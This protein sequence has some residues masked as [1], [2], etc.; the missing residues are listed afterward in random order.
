M[1]KKILALFMPVALAAFSAQDVLA[2]NFNKPVAP[3]ATQETLRIGDKA[4]SARFTQAIE[5]LPLM[6]GLEIDESD[7]LV[8]VFGS[9]RIART[10]AKGFVDIDQVYYFY[11]E[12][13]P[14][15]GW[16]SLSARRYERSGEILYLDA[17]SANEEGVTIVT[18]EIKPK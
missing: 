6:P 1:N 8:F 14:Q 11:Q 10:T 2:S 15:L 13:L 12:T 3:D 17:S 7:D 18:F 16:Q 4:K 9:H 5:D